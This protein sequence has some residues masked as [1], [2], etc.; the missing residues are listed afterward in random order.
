MNDNLLLGLWRFLVRIP[1]SIWQAQVARSAHAA[2]KSLAFMTADHHRVRDFVV[3]ELP[4]IAEPIPPATIAR[5]LDLAPERVVAILDELE[6]NLTFLYRNEA[7][8]VMWAYPVTVEPTPHR[9]TFSTGEQI[10]AA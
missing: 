6:K 4:R 7:G 5:S 3:V 1:R 9:V 10:Y 8:A 2:E